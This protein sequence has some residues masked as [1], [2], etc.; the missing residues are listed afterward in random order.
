MPMFFVRKEQGPSLPLYR[1]T[2]DM[3]NEFNSYPPSIM[4]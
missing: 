4:K 2:Q 3:Y 1:G